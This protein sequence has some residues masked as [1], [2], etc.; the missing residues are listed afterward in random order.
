VQ[1]Y[2]SVNS[3]Q[4]YGHLASVYAE[5]GR[6]YCFRGTG[7]QPFAGLQYIQLHSSRF[8]ETGAGAANLTVDNVD[9]GSLQSALGVRLCRT[10]C[11]RRGWT[12]RPSLQ[13]SWMH[14]F[15]ETQVTVDVGS[16]VPVP[17]NGLDLGRDRAVLGTG[18][19]LEGCGGVQFFVNYDLQLNSC[20]TF[21]VGYGGLAYEW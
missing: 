11:T 13:A 14:E 9:V 7:V 17:V 10:G 6:D 12:V 15:L 20:Q 19:V 2:H 3:Q 1:P 8:S 5:G 18:L 4:T 21:H 16:T